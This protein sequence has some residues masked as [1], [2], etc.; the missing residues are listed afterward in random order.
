M[1]VMKLNTVLKC[2][3]WW[4][5]GAQ[6]KLGFCS[7]VNFCFI[8]T[9]LMNK[10]IY[11][12][13]SKSPWLLAY[14]YVI[15]THMG[16]KGDL[17][18]VNRLLLPCLKRL[19]SSRKRGIQRVGLGVTGHQ[20]ESRAAHYV[21]AKVIARFEGRKSIYGLRYWNVSYFGTCVWC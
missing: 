15:I 21:H 14:L 2:N 16:P 4:N 18:D 19:F 20:E 6:L 13:L 11:S 9:I 1:H 8:I 12:V 7:N 3:V 17:Y 5:S 10:L